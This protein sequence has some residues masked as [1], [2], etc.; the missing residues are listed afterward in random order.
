MYVLDYVNRVR[1]DYPGLREDPP[2]TEDDGRGRR[3]G[4][5]QEASAVVFPRSSGAAERVSRLQRCRRH[6]R[7]QRAPLGRVLLV[8]RLLLALELGG[9]RLRGREVRF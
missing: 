1:G 9:A 2:S 3:E 4:R 8:R 5:G 6:P 7:A